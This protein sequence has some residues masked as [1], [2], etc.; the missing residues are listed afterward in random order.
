MRREP[1]TEKEEAEERFAKYTIN[2]VKAVAENN[3]RDGWQ[4]LSVVPLE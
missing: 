1:K 4:P 2:L 3:E